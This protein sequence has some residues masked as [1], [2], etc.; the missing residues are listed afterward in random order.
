MV[1]VKDS[2]THTLYNG[3]FTIMS[4]FGRHLSWYKTAATVGKVVPIQLPLYKLTMLHKLKLLV[5]F[6]IKATI[7]QRTC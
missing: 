7:T 2:V 5:K 4:A 6:T 3:V 1:E